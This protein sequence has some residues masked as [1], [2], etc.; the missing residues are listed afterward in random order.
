MAYPDD[1]YVDEYYRVRRP[2][3]LHLADSADDPDAKRAIL[4]DDENDLVAH[5][6]LYEID[7]DDLREVEYVYVEE[8]RDGIADVIAVAVADVIVYVAKDVWDK[9]GD[10]IIA[11]VGDKA[12][13][14]A[15][16]VKRKASDGVTL[17]MEKHAERKESKAAK[18]AERQ[19]KRDS[20]KSRKKGA[21]VLAQIDS[22]YK[23]YRKDMD[24]KEAQAKLLRVIALAMEL[25]AGIEELAHAN[26][27]DADRDEVLD[28]LSKPE[29]LSAVNNMLE[30]GPTAFD[31][32]MLQHMQLMLGRN[33]YENGEYV[34][35]KAD[36]MRLI[37]GGEEGSMPHMDDG[38]DG[39][40]DDGDGGLA[41][42]R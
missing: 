15:G 26:I 9:H 35:I 20:K 30:A 17:V 37:S 10:E 42:A 8:R 2:K 40:E 41:Q 11:W 1:G 29:L 34:P 5:A 18:K 23:G 24:S 36:E 33:L 32:T 28:F 39:E 4:F 38:G 14:A 6:E 13:R 3:D 19:L 12:S 7:R 22:A 25:S 16:T 21:K 27:V 31:A